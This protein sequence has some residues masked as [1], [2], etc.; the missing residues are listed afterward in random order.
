MFAS[1]LESMQFSKY[2]EAVLLWLNLI[3]MI[4]FLQNCLNV[5]L[6]SDS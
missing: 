3:I 2:R 6:V 4:N 5:I 1:D